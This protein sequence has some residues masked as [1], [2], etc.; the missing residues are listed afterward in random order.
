[1]SLPR[2]VNSRNVA[3]DIPDD[4]SSGSRTSAKRSG[5]NVPPTPATKRARVARKQTK[6][7]DSACYALVPVA[8]GAELED[9]RT[10]HPRGTTVYATASG[11]PIGLA[12]PTASASHGNAS[13][14]PTIPAAPAALSVPISA[15]ALPATAPDPMAIMAAM[16]SVL[17]DEQKR[18]MA[19]MMLPT[20]G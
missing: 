18:A 11:A 20:S 3:F 2:S 19:L 13:A 17:T 12:V 7:T 10:I 8:H 14:V 9:L 15:P 6:D 5:D 16:M 1:M 4:T